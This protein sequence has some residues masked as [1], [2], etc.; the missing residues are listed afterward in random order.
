MHGLAIF[1][2]D[3]FSSTF[4]GLGSFHL[5]VSPSSNIRFLRS[6]WRERKLK[7]CIGWILGT[8]LE[9]ALS[10]LLTPY[11]LETNHLFNTYF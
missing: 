2:G 6:I 9:V 10:L 1:L 4:W 8:D 11:Q 7:D 5:K 3:K